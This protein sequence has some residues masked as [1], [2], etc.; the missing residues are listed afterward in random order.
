MQT[1]V[2]KES[3]CKSTRPSGDTTLEENEDTNEEH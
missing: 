3:S 2:K 1:D